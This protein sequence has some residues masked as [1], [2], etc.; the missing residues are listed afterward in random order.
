MS[1]GTTRAI[2][3]AIA[4]MRLNSVSVSFRLKNVPRNA[5]SYQDTRS[6]AVLAKL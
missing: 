5:R 2:A 3:S 4:W 1:G 6:L